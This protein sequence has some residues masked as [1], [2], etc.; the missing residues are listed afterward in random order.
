MTHKN[1]KQFRNFMFSSARCSLLRAEGRKNTSKRAKRNYGD[2]EKQLFEKCLKIP[3]A[4]FSVS[5]L[6]FVHV[7]RNTGGKVQK[8][9]YFKN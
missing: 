2:Y 8:Q 7:G 5:A 9:P 1:R 6:F 4:I 3:C